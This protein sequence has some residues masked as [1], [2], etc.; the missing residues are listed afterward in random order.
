[1]EN[2]FQMLQ[3]NYIRNSSKVLA[4]CLD[5]SWLVKG[6]YKDV[7]SWERQIPQVEIVQRNYVLPRPSQNDG[8]FPSLSPNVA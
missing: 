7:D 3:S 4:S 6:K 8:K 1:M 2:V 5:V